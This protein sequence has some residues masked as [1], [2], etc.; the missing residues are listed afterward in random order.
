M[1]K[2][3]ARIEALLGE[4]PEFALDGGEPWT[5]AAFLEFAAMDATAA[6]AWKALLHHAGSGEAAKPSRKWLGQARALMEAIGEG[7]FKSSVAGWFA[8]V[9]PLGTAETAAQ[10]RISPVLPDRNAG[11][12]RGLVW[13]CSMVED[14]GLCRAIGDLAVV[15]FKKMPNWGPL[16]VR[17]GNACI[18]TLGALRGLEPVGQLGRLQLKVKYGSAQKLIERALDD[19]AERAG[20]TREDLDDLGVP[21]YGLDSNGVRTERAGSFTAELRVSGTAECEL[22]WRTEDG[23]EQKAVP[24]EVKRDH[25]DDLK[26]IKRAVQDVGKMLPVQRDRIERLLLAERTWPLPTWRTRYL[27]HP[28]LQ[29]ISR[30]LIWHVRRGERSG[31]CIW[32]DGRLV[33]SQSRALEWLGEDTVVSLWHPLGSDS[34]TVRAWRNYLQRNQV[35]QPLKQAHREIYILTDVELRSGTYS[36]RFAA[37]VIRQHQFAALCR[38]RGWTY[39]LQGGFDSGDNTPTLLLPRLDLRVEFWVEGIVDEVMTG[40]GIYL[41][42]ATDQVR[43]CDAAGEPRALRDVPSLVFSEVMRDVDLFVGVCSIGNDPE[44]QDHGD[45][46]HGEYW[47]RFAFG[48]LSGSAQTRRAMLE[49][50]LPRVRIADRCRLDGKFLVVRGV[51][52]TYKI[53]LGSA[54]ILMEPNDQYLCIVPGRSAADRREPGNVLLPFEGDTALSLILSKA[55]LLAND[56]QIKDPT[57][58]NQIRRP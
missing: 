33:D 19:S 20:L 54:N 49:E 57:I 5:D 18:Y 41:Q 26:R 58:M 45:A 9:A 39:R 40:A 6:Q 30:R 43:F 50:L 7:A 44:W 12:L 2:I 27:D 52:R 1:R 31:L 4:A 28:L 3:I 13:C 15:C 16:S 38:E 53:H 56:A 46:R 37:H 42:V 22:R 35:A 11:V 25:P 21:D 51:L 8:R 14:P 10:L 55:F 23:A 29:K 48:E 34:D 36:N 47:T 17:V 32:Q 24:A